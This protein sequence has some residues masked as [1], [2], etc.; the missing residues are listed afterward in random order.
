MIGTVLGVLWDVWVLVVWS[1]CL[2]YCVYRM[3]HERGRYAV[4]LWGTLAMFS[5]YLA[6]LSIGVLMAAT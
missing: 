4:A 3:T 1:G 5:A 6:W 2:G